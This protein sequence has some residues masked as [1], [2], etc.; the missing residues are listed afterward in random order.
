MNSIGGTPSYVVGDLVATGAVGIGI[1]S[2]ATY[3]TAGGVVTSSATS[4]GPWFMAWNTTSDNGSAAVVMRKDR[5]GAIVASGDPVMRFV[6]QGYDG[7]AYRTVGRIELQI[8]GTPNA[9]DMPSRWV[10]TTTPA[11][12]IS[13]AE[14]L[15]IDNG[16]NVIV[17]TAALA[18]NATAG[19]LWIPS[20]AGT[21]SGA[22]TAPYTNAAALIID[23][24]ASKIWVRVGTTWKSVAVV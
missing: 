4:N 5:A 23:T 7:G 6:G 15:R 18:T 19:F 12:T 1:A 22:P 20:C 21:P 16:G 11:G 2:P 17:G 13:P 24:T 10:F 9:S 8:D 3:V 14:R